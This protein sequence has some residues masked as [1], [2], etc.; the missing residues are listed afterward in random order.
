[1]SPSI[2]VDQIGPSQ[3]NYNG[4]PYPM[5][6]TF[7]ATGSGTAGVSVSGDT[8]VSLRALVATQKVKFGV[9]FSASMT[10]TLG[11]SITVTSPPRK[12]LYGEYG[13]WRKRIVGTSYRIYSNC[14]TST[15]NTV[16]S[17][18]PYHVGWVTWAN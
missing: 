12:T 2:Y 14:T 4:S 18:T 6:S 16:V 5:T 10:A 17:Y 1:M 8:E 7:T 13:V 11:N 9:A 3:A 15:H